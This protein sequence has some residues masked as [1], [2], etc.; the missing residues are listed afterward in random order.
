MIVVSTNTTSQAHLGATAAALLLSPG[1]N[2]VILSTSTAPSWE[3]DLPKQRDSGASTAL[4][5]NALQITKQSTAETRPVEWAEEPPWHDRHVAGVEA[6]QLVNLALEELPTEEAIES[7]EVQFSD[8]IEQHGVAGVTALELRLLRAN[9]PALEP[10]GWVFLTALG[11][12]R[13][14]SVDAVARQILVGEIISSSAG[15]R[16]AA[17]SAMGA[18]S[19]PSTLATLE[20]RAAIETN[21]VVLATLQAHI[22]VLK[23]NGISAKTAA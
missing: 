3:N 13:D 1:T 15:R 20:Q 5:I 12:S 14:P 16:A 19:S 17:A 7:F 9:D 21:R 2:F 23:G 6:Q 10:W 4:P 8:F 18:F 22:R 11:Y